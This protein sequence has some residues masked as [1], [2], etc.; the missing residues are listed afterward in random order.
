M[1]G[2]TYPVVSEGR[3]LVPQ[4]MVVLFPTEG[5]IYERDF[6]QTGPGI[7]V[8]KRF[9]DNFDLKGAFEMR[10]RF[11]VGSFLKSEASHVEIRQDLP[12]Q[13]LSPLADVANLMLAQWGG[14]DGF[15]RTNGSP[16]VLY[17]M[18]KNGI[19]G[20]SLGWSDWNRQWL[21]DAF[22]PTNPSSV[23]DT[24][25]CRRGTWVIC[26]GVILP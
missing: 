22:T 13:H 7:Y 8:T 17:A 15:L 12:Q 11:Y 1:G 24:G 21:L 2:G 20:L 18:G 19:L 6:F 14:K 3:F 25:S 23:Y 5:T 10:K 4:L 9:S 16:S 26:P